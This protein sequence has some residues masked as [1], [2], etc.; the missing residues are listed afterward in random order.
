MVTDDGDLLERILSRNKSDFMK[1]PE[2][3]K[4]LTTTL[5]QAKAVTLLARLGRGEIAGFGRFEGKSAQDILFGRREASPRKGYRLGFIESPTE[6]KTLLDGEVYDVA[7]V[8]VKPD[9]D[10]ALLAEALR[11]NR[12]IEERNDR[13][14]KLHRDGVS[15]RE[16]AALLGIRRKIVREALGV[17]W[18]L[19]GGEWILKRQKAQEAEVRRR[20]GAK[21]S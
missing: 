1:R 5:T 6:G 18:P 14:D 2:L 13:I 15:M 8:F 9:I 21:G 12:A 10:P 20:F 4:S 11:E 3:M 19:P 7:A 17:R 16:I